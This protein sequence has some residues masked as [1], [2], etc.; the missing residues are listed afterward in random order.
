M[1][2]TRMQT[3]VGRPQFTAV[4]KCALEARKL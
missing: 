3:G 1:C 4:Y 2:T